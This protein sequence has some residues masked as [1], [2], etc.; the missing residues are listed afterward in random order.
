MT[1]WSDAPEVTKGPFEGIVRMLGTA[2][3]IKDKKFFSHLT[4]IR[5]GRDEGAALTQ[6]SKIIALEFV[7]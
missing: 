3:K 2:H 7:G 1:E 5:W 6:H 4:I